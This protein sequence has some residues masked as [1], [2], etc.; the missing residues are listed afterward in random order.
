MQPI[1]HFFDVV[2]YDRQFVSGQDGSNAAHREAALASM[3]R[4]RA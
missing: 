4:T 2:P 3:C 1:K